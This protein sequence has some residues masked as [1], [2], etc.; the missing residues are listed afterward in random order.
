M[1]PLHSV[2]LERKGLK[3]RRCGGKGMY[4]RTDVMDESG[5]RQ[6][7]RPTS[8]PDRWFRLDNDYGK[9]LA[10][11]GYRGRQPVGARAD[12]NGVVAQLG[13]LRGSWRFP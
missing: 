9:A 12:Y 10:R 6:L 1:H 2:A 7:G 4:R 8:S 3:E 5:E 11:Q 13:A